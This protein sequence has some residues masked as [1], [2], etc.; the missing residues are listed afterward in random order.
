MISVSEAKKIIEANTERLS[1]RR[2]P[3]HL[4]NSLMLAE[5]IFSPVNI[6]PFNQSSMDGYAFA[7]DEW[8]LKSKLKIIGMIPAGSAE[9]FELKPGAAM[10][11]F[12]GAP[13]PAAADTVVMQEKTR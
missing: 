10:R 7:F 2:I 1:A 5:D 3:L 12:T 9:N 4:A 8:K 13:L 6:P 11:I